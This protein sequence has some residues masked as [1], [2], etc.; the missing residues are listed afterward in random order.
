MKRPLISARLHCRSAP[1][2]AACFR[3][4]TRYQR[5]GPISGARDQRGNTEVVNQSGNRR[6]VE[7]EWRR[8]M[9]IDEA[10][11]DEK[12]DAIGQGAIVEESGQAQAVYRS[13][14]RFVI[15]DSM[16]FLHVVERSM[17]RSNCLNDKFSLKKLELRR[18]AIPKVYTSR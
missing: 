5:K 11:R 13:G 3:H 14:S 1:A 16:V 15:E 18:C 10:E 9:R 2:T 8:E 7:T 17:T 4:S 12:M 6:S